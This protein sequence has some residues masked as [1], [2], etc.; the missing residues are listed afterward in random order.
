MDKQI[1][2]NL[3]KGL[4]QRCFSLRWAAEVREGFQEE[5]QRRAQAGAWKGRNILG[6]IRLWHRTGYVGRRKVL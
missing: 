3:V 2:E 4:L 5:V 6:D 1:E